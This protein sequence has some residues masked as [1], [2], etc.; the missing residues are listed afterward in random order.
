M[1]ISH[2][3]LLFGPPCRCTPNKR[4]QK[5]NRLFFVGGGAQLHRRTQDFTMEGVHVVGPGQE[6]WGRVPLAPVGSTGKASV[7][8]LGYEVPQKLKENVK[9]AYNF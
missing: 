9:L 6:V 4:S 2:S 5:C 3:G 1:T 8:N 7:G